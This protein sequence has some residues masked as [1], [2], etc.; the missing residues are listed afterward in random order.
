ME[1][2][3]QINTDALNAD[4]LEGIKKMFASKQVEIIIREQNTDIEEDATRF[5]LNQPAL[6]AELQKRIEGIEN[7]TGKL[8]SI[9]AEDL[10]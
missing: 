10:L 6:A 2:T 4:F 1:T 8:L 5:I 9:E 3:I 7:K